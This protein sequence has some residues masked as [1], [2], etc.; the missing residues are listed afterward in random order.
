MSARTRLDGTHGVLDQLRAALS[1]PLSAEG[2][3]PDAGGPGRDEALTARLAACGAEMKMG[4]DS[5]PEALVLT[6]PFAS[7]MAL[8]GNAAAGAVLWGAE[9]A[10]G[11]MQTFGLMPSA[12]I[13]RCVPPRRVGLP[14]PPGFIGGYS[15][16]C[17]AHR[18]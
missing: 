7:H 2:G 14:A 8:V 12:L 10:R 3:D 11:L 9:E 15:S 17:R 6:L 1:L 18:C 13:A 5:A 4:F 16:A